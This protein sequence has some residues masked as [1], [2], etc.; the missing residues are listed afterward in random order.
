MGSLPCFTLGG[1][2]S[3]KKADTAEH[4]CEL[5]AGYM[6]AYGIYE[7]DE[8]TRR[9]SDGKVKG[10]ARTV[11]DTVTELL[12][13]QHLA[14]EL[15]IGIITINEEDQC[16]WGCIDVD[17]YSVDHKKLCQLIKALKLPLTVCRTKSGGAHCY[18][19]FKE[20]VPAW[21]VQQKLT[22]WS[23]VL[24]HG[25]SEIFPKQTTVDLEAD[26][27]GSWVN[28]P[29]YDADNTMRYAYDSQ[30]NAMDAELFLKKAIRLDHATFE[31]TEPKKLAKAPAKDDD[32]HD[33]PVCFE[34]ITTQGKVS[35]GK[36]NNALVSIAVYC[37]KKWPD[38]W[39]QHVHRMNTEYLQPPLPA[40]EVGDIIKHCSRK[41]YFYLCKQE[42]LLSHCNGSLCRTRPYGVGDG[43]DKTSVVIS[44]LRKLD[45][46]PPI[47]YMDITDT[48]TVSLTT[49]QLASAA[50]FKKA[51]MEQLTIFPVVNAK[52]WQTLLVDVMD[53]VVLVEISEEEK[54]HS[55]VVG[56]FYQH[57]VDF[58][59][60]AHGEDEEELLLRKVWKHKGRLIFRLQDLMEHL[61]TRRFSKYTRPMICQELKRFGAKM[62]TPKRVKGV[63]TRTWSIQDNWEQTE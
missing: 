16:H 47:W 60:R 3:R 32:F 56:E 26:D 23:A 14:G 45:T 43:E 49:D 1:V 8:S 20:P 58:F 28:M 36:R 9:S 61:A 10:Q 25:G 5:F 46:D 51:C 21:L 4:M 11:R 6:E 27:L 34:I 29:Y 18:V 13:K 55:G 44:E 59:Q 48:G 15:P 24:G 37:K 7:I 40:G 33:G 54:E 57:L 22:N 17:D 52:Q 50:L 42:P 53:R 35:S 19:F 41:D 62:E 38:D 30:G 2:V 31:H 12:W 39:A 63:V